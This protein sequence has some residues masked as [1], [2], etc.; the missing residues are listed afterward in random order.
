MKVKTLLIHVLILF[1]CT[2]SAICQQDQLYVSAAL[3]IHISCNKTVNLVFTY[4]IKS[5]D[6]GSAYVLAQKARGVQNVLQLKAANPQLQQT[7]LTVITADG[8]IHTFLVDYQQDPMQFVIDV[9]SSPSQNA[10]FSDLTS[11]KQLEMLAQK[12][13]VAQPAR[14]WIKDKKGGVKIA[15]TGLYVNKDI[16]FLRLKIKNSTCVNYHIESD[17]FWISDLKRIKRTASQ[18]DPVTPLQIF[19][20]T[21]TIAAGT[22]SEII[23]IFPA[24]TLPEQKRF[25]IALSEKN[26]GRHLKLALSNRQIV[27]AKSL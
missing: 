4:P 19:N 26:G 15:M 16:F 14:K 12:A 2:T 13:A 5:V 24:F 25:W 27:R 18:S 17:K 6:K 21:G 23:Y 7:N 22:E 10:L 3:P 20:H 9:V 11:Q 8:C 1:F